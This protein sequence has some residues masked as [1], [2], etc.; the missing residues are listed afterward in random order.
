M[1]SLGCG[2]SNV[3][4]EPNELKF[5]VEEGY[6]FVPR[7]QY[8]HLKKDGSGTGPICTL[9]SESDWINFSPVTGDVPKRIRVGIYSI[10]KP[11]GVYYGKILVTSSAATEIDPNVIDVVL[12]VEAKKEPIPDPE[13]EPDPTP[14]PDPEPTEPEPDPVEPEPDPP[15]QENGKKKCIICD[16]IRYIF[17]GGK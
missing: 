14:V 10:G 3:K 12:T 1:E 16:I 15:E 13:P 6:K 5:S 8:V 7:Y 4:V 11:R 17:R 2:Y 9:S